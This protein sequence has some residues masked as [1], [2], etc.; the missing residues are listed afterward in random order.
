MRSASRV[1]PGSIRREVT[2]SRSAAAVRADLVSRD[3]EQGTPSGTRHVRGF[4][5]TQLRGVSHGDS[6]ASAFPDVRVLNASPLVALPP[7]AG[8]TRRA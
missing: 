1:V 2:L 8:A 6:L 7:A 3:A 5:D 4:F